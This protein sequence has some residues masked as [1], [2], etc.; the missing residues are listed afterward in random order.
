MYT[1]WTSHLSDQEKKVRF[2]RQILS[3]SDV[4]ARLYVIL[5]EMETNLSRSELDPSVFKDPN[6]PYHQAY[7]NGKRAAIEDLKRLINLDQQDTN[8]NE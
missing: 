2:E 5:E 1:K 3:S 7:K 4:L 8:I 6:W